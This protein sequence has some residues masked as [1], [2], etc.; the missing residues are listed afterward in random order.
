MALRNIKQGP[1]EKVEEYYKRV[2]KLSNSLHR[3]TDDGFLN[4]IFKAGL[5][6]YLRLATAGLQ[7]DTLFNHKEAVVHCE[8][9][10]LEQDLAVANKE[11]AQAKPQKEPPNPKPSPKIKKVCGCC[12]KLGHGDDECWYNPNN[13][14]INMKVIPTAAVEAQPHPNPPPIRPYVPPPSP[15]SGT[16]LRKE[17]LPRRETK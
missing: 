2:E 17:C 4:S 15:S 16:R 6:P 8:E 12:G 7:R 9:E 5:L 3:P 11:Y 10:V 13:R 14:N 1:K